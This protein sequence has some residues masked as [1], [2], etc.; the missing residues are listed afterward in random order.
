MAS[1]QQLISK[2]A[3]R[4][5]KELHTRNPKGDPPWRLEAPFKKLPERLAGLLSDLKKEGSIEKWSDA[6]L[7]FRGMTRRVA[8]YRKALEEREIPCRSSGDKRF[9]RKPFVK[10]LVGILGF[11]HKDPSKITTRIRKHHP[12]FE[13]LDHPDKEKRLDLLKQ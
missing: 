3:A 6:A 8:E 11:I 12:F 1:T 13:A 2:N 9:L 5:P 7:L 10:S 4:H